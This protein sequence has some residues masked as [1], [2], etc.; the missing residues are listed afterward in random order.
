MFPNY[1]LLKGACI[2][3]SPN[4]TFAW[5]PSPLPDP[6]CHNSDQ[7]PSFSNRNSATL[8][9]RLQSSFTG[10]TMMNRGHSDLTHAEYSGNICSLYKPLSGP[11]PA[12]PGWQ[13][14]ASCLSLQIWKCPGQF[15]SPLV[16][17]YFSLPATQW[18]HIGCL[19]SAKHSGSALSS[20]STMQATYVVLNVLVST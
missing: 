19:L 5:G 6:A 8:L 18:V 15:C 16:S 13:P 4:F 14:M 9:L 11:L 1:F 10:S 2:T 20:K 3:V 12:S 17:C 7:E